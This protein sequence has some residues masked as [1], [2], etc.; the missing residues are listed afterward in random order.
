MKR[1]WLG[2]CRNET[3]WCYCC[4]T[5][6]AQCL[7][8]SLSFVFIIHVHPSLDPFF[9]RLAIACKISKKWT[10]ESEHK[11]NILHGTI[12]ELKLTGK[13]EET[14]KKKKC[15]Q[16]R[17]DRDKL[18]VQ[19]RVKTVAFDLKTNIY[20]MFTNGNSDFRTWLFRRQICRFAQKA[21]MEKWTSR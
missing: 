6:V 2:G 18:C 9:F 16:E 19:K 15:K 10:E 4:C 20:A 3:G 5:N 17:W 7:G 8:N 11:T 21:P 1:F 13:M 12:R 14:E